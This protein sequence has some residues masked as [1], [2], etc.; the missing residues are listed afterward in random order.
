[1]KS[2]NL[3]KGNTGADSNVPARFSASAP[4]SVPATASY[5][6]SFPPLSNASSTFQSYAA[7][8]FTESSADLF[9]VHH[10][11]HESG[12]P[13]PRWFQSLNTPQGISLI[14]S[15]RTPPDLS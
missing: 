3:E 10:H 4:R 14:F 8:G 12:L 11:F 5:F 15:I 9:G 6:P 7:P 1:M 13:R 2:K